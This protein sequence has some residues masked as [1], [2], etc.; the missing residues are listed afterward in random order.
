MKS[1]T[2]AQSWHDLGKSKFEPSCC[3]N[4]SLMLQLTLNKY[5]WQVPQ[6]RTS[7]RLLQVHDVH[8]K[9]G[10]ASFQCKCPATVQRKRPTAGFLAESLLY[11]PGGEQGPKSKNSFRINLGQTSKSPQ[12]SLGC[13]YGRNL[14]LSPSAVCMWR[15][16]TAAFIDKAVCSLNVETSPCHQPACF[17]G[18]GQRRTLRLQSG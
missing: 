10:L 12:S 18:T 1:N 15:L 4:M 11:R 14:A 8:R 3:I 5:G 6:Q 7:L 2:H 16:F 13:L 9:E 17:F